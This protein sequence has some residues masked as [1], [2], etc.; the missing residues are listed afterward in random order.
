MIFYI[1]AGLSLIRAFIAQ[2]DDHVDLGDADETK[3]GFVLSFI[4]TFFWMFLFHIIAGGFPHGFLNGLGYIIGLL[5]FFMMAIP[6]SI[7]LFRKILK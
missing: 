3:F 2:Q 7:F 5:F 6:L 4:V 1:I